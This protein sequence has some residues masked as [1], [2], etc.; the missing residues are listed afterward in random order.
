MGVHVDDAI[1]QEV[2]QSLAV[3]GAVCFAEFK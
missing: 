1:R 2:G 3:E